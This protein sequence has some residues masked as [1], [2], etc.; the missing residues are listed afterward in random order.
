M[1]CDDGVRNASRCTEPIDG[2]AAHRRESI[3][4]LQPLGDAPPRQ[5]WTFGTKDNKDGLVFAPHSRV[6]RVALR[7]IEEEFLELS[8]WT[9][10]AAPA[11]GGDRQPRP[12]PPTA[13][14]MGFRHSLAAVQTE[15][16]KE[17]HGPAT[18]PG[19]DPKNPFDVTSPASTPVSGHPSR[20][21]PRRSV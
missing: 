5:R 4:A 11:A 17:T 1:A 6:S 3:C 20:W 21:L 19:T 13:P 7:T 12:P 9:C 10:P 15:Q 2:L 8:D 16:T 14:R 18:E